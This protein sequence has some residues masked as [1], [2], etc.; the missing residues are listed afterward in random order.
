MNESQS[1]IALAPGTDKSEVLECELCILGAGV[2]GLNALFAASRQLQS[3]Q[4]IVMVD[5]RAAPAGMWRDVYSY[6]RLH[7][8]H[9]MFTAGNIAW[10]G[11]SDPAHLA[12]ADAVVHLA[13][14]NIGD[15]RWTAA[16]KRDVLESRVQGTRLIA[17]TLAVLVGRA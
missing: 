4:K 7:Q 2:A 3:N 6:V 16:V 17:E 12:D 14:A 5:R 15:K 9:P 11:Q 8:P 13:G 10:Q 1:A